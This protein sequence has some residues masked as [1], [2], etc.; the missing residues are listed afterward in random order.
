VGGSLLVIGSA[1]GIIAMSKV[2]ELTFVSYLKYVPA[3]MLCYCV[4]YALTLFMAK[5]IHG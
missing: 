1:S 3:L 4:G 5:H 2:K